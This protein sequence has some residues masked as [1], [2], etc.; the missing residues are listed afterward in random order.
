M[1]PESGQ[2]RV[3]ILS[4]DEICIPYWTHLDNHNEIAVFGT[5]SDIADD[6]P[7][8]CA[9]MFKDKRFMD[10]LEEWG[11][12][13]LKSYVEGFG[14]LTQDFYA[15]LT[16]LPISELKDECLDFAKHYNDCHSI[17]FMQ[18]AIGRDLFA[19]LEHSF[20]DFVISLPPP[21]IHHY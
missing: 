18:D 2:I 10:A 14:I 7:I 19:R 5:R 6:G 16:S 13:P 17:I 3:W 21:R 9:A 8:I 1:D 4:K 15:F 12:W 20:W 11:P